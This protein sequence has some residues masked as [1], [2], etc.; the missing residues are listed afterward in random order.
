MFQIALQIFN[1]LFTLLTW[2]A[3]GL[4]LVTAATYALWYGM[5]FGDWIQACRYDRKL[6]RIEENRARTD[7]PKIIEALREATDALHDE[8]RKAALDCIAS[9]LEGGR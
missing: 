6:R 2:L 1:A 3:A 7:I 9:I 5:K 8:G 4:V